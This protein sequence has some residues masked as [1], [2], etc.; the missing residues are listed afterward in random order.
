MTEA[1]SLPPNPL[2]MRRLG[3]SDLQVSAIG[4][5]CMPMSSVY[6][7]ADPAD[8][9]A[10]LDAALD[11]GITFWDT[12]NVYGAGEN[13]SLLAPWLSA[14]REDIVLATKF[15]FRPDGS[16]SARP[17]DA[18]QSLDAS[19]QRLGVDVIDLWYLH[20]VDPNV[21][22]EDTV[23][24][25][26]DAVLAGKV[27]YL[28]LS[29]AS[30]ASIRRACAVHPI[31]ALQSEW[32]L[33]T[34]DLEAEVLA[35][36]RECG[37][38]IV[39]YSPLG[40]GM[41]AGSATSLDDLAPD[42]YRRQGPRFSA[43]AFDA[44][45]ESLRGFAALALERDVTPGQLALAWLLAQGPDVVPIPGTRRPA[46]LRDNAA[47]AHVTLTPE[48]CRLIESAVPPPLGARYARDHAYGDSPAPG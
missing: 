23:G 44:N 37:V 11:A 33:W 18:A 25:M 24:A 4:L 8:V 3:N 5:G 36:A 46:H 28:G 43:D 38:G 1:H 30:S 16:V 7:P 32:S 31:A 26:R 34:R 12:A 42:D 9:A 39:P 17:E 41:L 10:T 35:T 45:R 48:D 20:R 47:A 40:R 15:G 27:R 19:L 22:I 14:Q 2:P 6:G 21:P 13:E 29:E